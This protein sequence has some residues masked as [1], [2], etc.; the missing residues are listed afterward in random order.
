MNL[1]RRE[2]PMRASR[3]RTCFF[4]GI[5]I[6]I[7]CVPG[8]FAQT[9]PLSVEPPQINFDAH[10]LGTTTPRILT[11]RNTGGE[12]LNVNVTVLGN[13]PNEFSWNSTCLS[14][15]AAGSKCDVIV[16]FGPLSIRKIENRE[17]QLKIS[18]GKGE[19]QTV[20]LTGSAYQNLAFSPTQL[21]FEDQPIDKPGSP[22]ALVVTNYSDATLPSITVAT[23]GDFAETHTKCE[24]IAPGASC[25]VSV[26]FSPKISGATSGSLTITADQSALGKLPR[27]V[28]L[29]GNGL[30]K[31]KIPA[32]SFWSWN[33]WI[34]GLIGGLYFAGL[35]MVRWHMI[36]KPVR[37]QLVTQIN[38][39]R[40]L[41]KAESAAISSS[42]AVDERIARINYLLDWALYPFKNK[43]FPVDKNP[44]GSE[45]SYLPGWF[46]WYTRLFNAVFWPR[47]QELAGWSCSHEAELLLVELLPVE[48]VRARMET[49]E[50]GLRA[51]N[52][53]VATS[54]A[55]TLHAA[56][57]SSGPPIPL[58][59]WRALLA[60]A[61]S[62]LYEQSD[63]DFFELATWHSKMMWLVGSALL[64]IFGLAVTLQNAVLLLV[65]A[66][67]GLLSRL[68]RT[69]TSAET[70]N[71]YGASWGALFLSPLSGAL[72]AWGG[73][74]LIIL[75]LRFNI[76]G[77][78]LNVDWCNPYDPATL[79]IA[80][81]FGFSERLFDGIATQIE[82]KI[83]KTQPASQTAQASK[84]G[85]AIL[86]LDPTKAD[87]GKQVSFTV[88][89]NNFALGATATVTDEHGNPTQVNVAYQDS[90]TLGVVATL[91]GAGAFTS[92]L[93]ITNPDK[94]SA[95]FRFE[96]A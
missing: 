82:Q 83:I 50:Y 6:G 17:A 52:T 34:A 56:T 40:S 64:F 65:G 49:A 7:V 93:T 2:D 63:R 66:V 54:L 1:A 84:S 73:I 36:A 94:Q 78:A 22:L 48:R 68:A 75:G 31:C 38:A 87:L 72:S 43:N 35:V 85:P 59:R 92:T 21:R 61:L 46:P 8:G 95:T 53:P 4:A 45:K 3:F 86:S 5:T 26:V 37:A 51:L 44:D 10:D 18:S 14:N 20:N 15:L 32:I 13:D 33:F 62:V 24:K 96:V 77:T 76:L 47:G 57:S 71:D 29:Q 16:S 42:P 88:H 81:L 90:T 80:L 12:S 9:V 67:G 74:L 58:D 91:A 89:G 25:A 30:T 79:A 11:V 19:P 39:V 28:L 55:A 69:V 41:L 70:G 23:T 60:E 27:V